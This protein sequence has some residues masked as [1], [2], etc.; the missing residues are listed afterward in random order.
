MKKKVLILP[1]LLIMLMAIGLLMLFPKSKVVYAVDNYLRLVRNE[2]VI[3][4][5]SSFSSA[6]NAAQDGDVIELTRDYSA[7]IQ[8]DINKNVIIDYCDYTLALTGGY[9]M[10]DSD[11]VVFRA[12]GSGGLTRSSK[13]VCM[14][15]SGTNFGS[16]IHLTIESGV[17]DVFNVYY[18]DGDAQGLDSANAAEDLEDNL[19]IN[20]GTFMFANNDIRNGF[21]NFISRWKNRK[22]YCP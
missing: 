17:Y 16:G 1:Y 10:V 8:V 14:G 5:Y 11:D 2:V 20:G 12:S 13:S 4:E 21:R 9:L 3:N 19:T 6:I 15:Y 22:K 7:N 18:N